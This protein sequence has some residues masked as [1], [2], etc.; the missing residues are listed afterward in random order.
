MGLEGSHVQ[1]GDEV[2]HS[3][4]T[5]HKGDLILLVSQE[6]YHLRNRARER[7]RER[8]RGEQNRGSGR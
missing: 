4:R 6:L 3:D 1:V 2:D 7:E 5:C 8:E